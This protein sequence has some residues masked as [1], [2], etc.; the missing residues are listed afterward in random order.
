MVDDR[1][2]APVR[3]GLVGL[4]SVC[5][6]VHY[7]GLR[8]IPGVQIAGLCDVDP[9]LLARRRQEWATGLAT[10]ELGALL[11]RTP[12]DAVIIATPNDTH[13]E[14]VLEAV[15]AGCHVLCEKPLALDHA[16]AAS[17]L[18]AAAAA[19]VRHMTAFTYRFAPGMRY[20]KH[21]VASGA[22]GEPRHARF[23][24][25]QYWGEKAIG[26][27]QYRC[28][29]GSGEIADMGIHRL[30][31]AED[32][33]GPIRAVCGLTRRLLDRT[34]QRDGTRCAPQ[35]S[36]TGPAGSRSSPAARRACS[37]WAS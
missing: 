30:D 28:R 37:R 12:L 4:G 3:V 26:W 9:V 33:L 13:R 27:R 11:R 14:L 6:A 34:E 22:L 25:L 35:D 19:G 23:Q 1:L 21:L 29:A 2:G 18:H 15:A 36:R 24:R 16:A 8:L 32:L 20:L 17:M 10:T 5:A 7:P 31:F